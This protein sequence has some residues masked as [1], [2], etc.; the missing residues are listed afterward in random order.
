MGPYRTAADRDDLN[1]DASMGTLTRLFWL[2]PVESPFVVIAVVSWWWWTCHSI[3]LL[4]SF[5]IDSVSL[6]EHNVA[7]MWLV[8]HGTLILVTSPLVIKRVFE[9]K[10]F[11]AFMDTL[12][13]T[14]DRFDEM[15]IWSANRRERILKNEELEKDRR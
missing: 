2:Y 9:T 3:S 6:R 13:S 4:F 15:F 5:F 10:A 14:L 7:G 11:V 1:P 12:A 8:L